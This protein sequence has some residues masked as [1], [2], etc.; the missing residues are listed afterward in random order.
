MGGRLQLNVDFG[1]RKFEVNRLR[2]ERNSAN[3]IEMGWRVAVIRKCEA[4]TRY[5]S[6][7]VV[8]SIMQPDAQIRS[9]L[10]AVELG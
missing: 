10:V 6:T 7:T 1:V 9:R 3:L 5:L 4:S 2:D 8:R